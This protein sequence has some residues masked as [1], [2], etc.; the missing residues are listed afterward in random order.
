MSLA[1]NAQQTRTQNRAGGMTPQEYARSTQNP[2]PYWEA[3][4][5]QGLIAERLAKEFPSEQIGNI[6]PQGQTGWGSFAGWRGNAPVWTGSSAGANYGGA[7]IMPTYGQMLMNLMGQG[8]PNS[9]SA[10]RHLPQYEIG[11]A[12]LQK[13]QEQEIKM[14]EEQPELYPAYLTAREETPQMTYAE[15]MNKTPYA[16][17]YFNQQQYQKMLPKQRK[18]PRWAVA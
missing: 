18:I 6:L 5:R 8:E 13:Q 11:R 1:E 3:T 4:A 9:W 12:L 2:V 15:W 10:T 17:A 7:G 14:Y 16:Q